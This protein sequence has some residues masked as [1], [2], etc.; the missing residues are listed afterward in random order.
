MIGG[1]WVLSFTVEGS[2]QS[3]SITSKAGGMYSIY[4]FL[5]IIVLTVVFAGALRRHIDR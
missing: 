5:Y 1:D 2:Y 4:L 3:S